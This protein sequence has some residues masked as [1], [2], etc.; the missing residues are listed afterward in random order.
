MKRLALLGFIQ[1]GTGNF[2]HNKGI[3]LVSLLFVIKLSE[4]PTLTMIIRYWNNVTSKFVRC[5]TND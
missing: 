4:I 5:Q 3:L 1:L 2:L